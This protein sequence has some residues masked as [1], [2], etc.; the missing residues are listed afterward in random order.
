MPTPSVNRLYVFP[1]IVLASSLAA[2]APPA[3][4]QPAASPPGSRAAAVTD[5]CEDTKG[6]NTDRTRIC[7]SRTVRIAARDLVLDASVNGSIHVEA[8][9]ESDIELVSI[10]QAE[11]PSEAEAR[12]LVDATDIETRGTVRARHP[13]LWNGR[14]TSISAS[15]RLRVPRSS[16]LDLTALNGSVI[17]SGVAGDVRVQTVN[18]S[19]RFDAMAGDV[20]GRTSNGSV[21]IALAGQSWTGRQLDVETTNGSVSITLPED[22]SADLTAST[23]MG[24]IRAPGL[25]TTDATFERGEWYGG[26]VEGRIGRGGAPIRAVTTNGSIRIQAVR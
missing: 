11:A 16:D 19:L 22:Y 23:K 13:D 8:W 7:E 14:D 3:T 25:V 24:R 9:D 20:V 2:C 4:S 15:F 26:S 6:W 12:R 18:G 17:I 10:I 21:S 1:L 5:P